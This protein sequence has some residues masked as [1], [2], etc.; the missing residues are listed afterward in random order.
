MKHRRGLFTFE[1]PMNIQTVATLLDF[2]DQTHHCNATYL[3]AVPVRCTYKRRTLWKGLV[4]T[5]RIRQGDQVVEC[6]AWLEDEL[7]GFSAPRVV[8]RSAAIATPHAAVRAHLRELCDELIS[9]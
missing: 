6:F 1:D 5:F 7:L 2:I 8:L 4:G 9:M 3:R